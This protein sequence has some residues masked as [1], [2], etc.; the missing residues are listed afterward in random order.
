VSVA[1]QVLLLAYI[2]GAKNP[3]FD[4][5]T[6][7]NFTGSYLAFRTANMFKFRSY[8]T[9]KNVKSKNSNNQVQ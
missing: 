6:A 5:R 4:P 2:S 3:Y 9:K 1:E 8:Q 7:V